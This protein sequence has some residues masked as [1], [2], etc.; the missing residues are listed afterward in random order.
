MELCFF[1]WCWGGIAK[2]WRTGDGTIFVRFFAVSATLYSIKELVGLLQ[3]T[4]YKI[5]NFRA[6]TR[7]SSSRDAILCITHMQGI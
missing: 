5:R 2:F 4:S 3:E 7:A 1:A 6:G